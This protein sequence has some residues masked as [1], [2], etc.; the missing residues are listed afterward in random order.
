M[1]AI[2]YPFTKSSRSKYHLTVH[3]RTSKL[4]MSKR[5]LFL[6]LV[7]ALI[8]LVYACNKR[9]EDAP[10]FTDSRTF[11]PLAIGKYITYSVD[12]TTWNDF[13]CAHNKTM[14]HYNMRYTVNDTF[15]DLSGHLS[16]SID[17]KNR[18]QTVSGGQARFL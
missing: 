18:T 8:F 10:A 2:H 6:L 7:P 16:Y 12:S 17:V 13:D 1:H 15:I 4:I 11:Y 14:H 5:L 3:L 9:T